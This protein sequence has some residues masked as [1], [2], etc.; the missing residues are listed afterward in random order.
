MNTNEITTVVFGGKNY[1][2]KGLFDITG[3]E[4]VKL[5]N[6]VA[7]KLKKAET[8]RF[9]TIGA[10]VT[11]TWALLTEFAANAV[12][13]RHPAPAAAPPKQAPTASLG[14]PATARAKAT[15]K[16]VS[17]APR[18]RRGTNLAAPGHAPIPCRVGSKQAMLLDK[19]SASNGAT[20]D[21]LLDALKDGNKPWTEAAVRSGFGWDMKQKGYGVKSVIG[22]DGVERF[23]IV[24]PIGHTIPAHRPLK[25]VPKADARQTKIAGA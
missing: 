17:D 23:F 8:R 21:E 4:L 19:L 2:Q 16:A 14:T 1:T 18:A 6:D 9:S 10:G 25:G 22:E 3:K 5:H 15:K 24:L 12:G 13:E 11:R 20:M 7:V